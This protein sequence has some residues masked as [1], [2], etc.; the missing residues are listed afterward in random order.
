MTLAAPARI[1]RQRRAAL[2][3]RHC[4][5]EQVRYKDCKQKN[6]DYTPGA[7]DERRNHGE[8]HQRAD[9]AGGAKIN[10]P[11]NPGT[12]YNGE[13]GRVLLLTGVGRRNWISSHTHLCQTAAQ[14]KADHPRTLGKTRI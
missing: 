3:P 7:I 2:D 10:Q 13:H 12:G 6:D 11:G 14:G 8:D 1:P 9:N 5:I 4:R